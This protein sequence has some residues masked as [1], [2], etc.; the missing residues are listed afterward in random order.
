MNTITSE[1]SKELVKCLKSLNAR[2]LDYLETNKYTV[3]SNLAENT[4]MNGNI[5]IV[6]KEVW[7]AREDL[8]KLINS[9]NRSNTDLSHG[10]ENTH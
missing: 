4:P 2:T 3:L 7:Q 6:L 8:E 5:V 9:L 1:L 10:P